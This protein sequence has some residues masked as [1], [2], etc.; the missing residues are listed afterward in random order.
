MSLIKLL[1]GG[2]MHSTLALLQIECESW[3]GDHP[4]CAWQPVGH[5]GILMI[6]TTHTHTHTTHRANYAT[7]L[8][9]VSFYPIENTMSVDGWIGGA[10]NFDD[11]GHGVFPQ[12][13]NTR[14]YEANHWQGSTGIGGCHGY[15]VLDCD[16]N[17]HAVKVCRSI[18]NSKVRMQVSLLL[19][20]FLA[21][22]FC[23]DRPVCG[24][25]KSSL[26]VNLPG[27]KKASQV[28][29]YMCT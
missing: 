15:K 6:I 19:K 18:I 27:S 22:L 16:P 3:A 28:H 9:S 24:I 26:I 14:S 4:V 23:D 21:L 1:C 5:T 12:R 2:L 8:M 25:R 20:N 17:G 11:R 29:V 10:A 7:H 13:C